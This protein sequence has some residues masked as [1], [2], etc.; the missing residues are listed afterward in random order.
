MQYLEFTYMRKLLVAALSLLFLFV[1]AEAVEKKQKSG[2]T[3]QQ[4][5]VKQESKVEAKKGG[6]PKNES[7]KYDSFVDKN[8]NGI[9]DRREKSAAEQSK[10]NPPAPS[11]SRSDTTTKKPK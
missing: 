10:K 2:S 11:K 9:D 4:P 7:K 3:S 8:R 1:S 5:S 6:Q